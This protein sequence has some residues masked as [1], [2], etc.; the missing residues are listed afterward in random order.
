MLY[1]IYVHL[2]DDE[3]AHGIT[4][5]D[6]PGCFSAA[7]EWSD[8]PGLVQEAIEV[9][10]EG[11]DQD[12]PEPSRIEDLRDLPEYKGGEWAF[13]DVNL[14]TLDTRKERIN[15]SIPRNAL[16]EIDEHVS[17]EGI[18]RSGFMVR[19]A[20]KIIRESHIA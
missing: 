3:H 6:F 8:V 13:V 20:L 1:P 14:D 12:I 7:D 9:Y 2:G 10:C 4:I 19:A 18:K 11:E 15:L 17:R 5:P 16:R